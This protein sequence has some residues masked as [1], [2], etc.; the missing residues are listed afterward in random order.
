MHE[1][2]YK[3]AYLKTMQQTIP[4]HDPFA[5]LRIKE[6]LFFLNTRFFLTL[7]IQMQSVIV[8]WQV[9]NI[10]HDKLALGLIGL[11]EAIPFIIVSFF[12]GH[13][14]D[15]VSRKLIILV[16][17]SLLI[18]STSALLYFSLDTS[19]VLK[20]YGTLP[21]YLVFGF[22]GIVRGFI[23]AAFPAFMSQI[24][25]RELYANSATWNSS[26]WHV[27]AVVGPAVAGIICLVSFSA[28]YTLNIIFI[29]LS[30]FSFIFIASKP[31]PIKEKKETLGESLSVGIKFVFS[32]QIIL[33]ALSLDL[34][35]VLFGGAVAML[36]AFTD[37]IL[38]VGSM[39]LG[40]LRAAPALGAI[41]TA[42]ILAYK[43]I[44]KNAGRN[45]FVN[46]ALFGVATILFAVSTNYYLSLF[47]LFLTGAFDNVSV[48]IRH[49][50]LQ[51][52]TPNEMRGRVSA[53]NSIFIGS[54]NEIGA[55]ESGL[56]AEIMGGNAVALVRSVIF[57]GVMTILV[58]AGTYKIAPKLRDLDLKKIE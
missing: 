57:G 19:S 40:F 10:T 11:A 8:G 51:L 36:P 21:I 15:I 22:I 27:G 54:S 16:S 31:I 47:F 43:P 13:V 6:F 2:N 30:I 37:E 1:I 9:Y 14:A 26:I 20:N 42:I 35:A 45:L 25:P 29:V 46:V 50:I 24:V 58:V 48:V 7:A 52:A 38:H 55:A 12:S 56:A 41:F 18:V 4:K 34:F 5:A 23:S 28:A 49:T 17:I 32:N 44:T 33:G 3:F 53:V 39:E